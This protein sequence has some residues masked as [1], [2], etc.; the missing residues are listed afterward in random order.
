MADNTNKEK[1]F[2]DVQFS[3]HPRIFEALGTDLV[4]NDT[5]A[6]IELV[7]NSYDAFAE[8]VWVR[9]LDDK[10]DGCIIE[11]EDDGKGMNREIIEDVWG[12]VATPYKTENTTTKSGDKQRRV[13]GEKGLG[14]LSVAR[15]GDHLRMLTQSEGNPCWEVKVKWSEIVKGDN[16]SESI[17][18]CRKY[19]KESPF[20]DS[21]TKLIISKLNSNWEQE[22]INELKDNLSR[23]KFPFSDI[24][25][26]NIFLSGI[27]QD[28]GELEIKTPKFLKNP[29]Y[30]IEGQVD[31]EGNI[32]SEYEYR[33][34]KQNEGRCEE[35][36]IPWGKI[37]EE[38]DDKTEFDYSEKESHCGPFTYEIRAWDLAAEDTSEISQKFNLE[39]SK[40]R[41]AIRAHKG[42]SVYRDDI[43]V[44]PKTD[45]SRDWL[46]LDL[47]R[48]SKIGSRL[49]TS[50]IVGYVS[51]SASD[52]PEIRDT[53]DRERLSSCLEV[54]EFKEIL[55]NIISI[56]E[57]ER[58]KDRKKAE[59]E[60]DDSLKNFLSK[61][62]ADEL[63]EEV[64][65]LAKEGADASDALPLVEEH[66]KSLDK[67][68]ED[69]EKRFVYYSRLSTIGTIAHM[70]VHEVRNQSTSIDSFIEEAGEK[71]SPFESEKLERFYKS[72]SKSI[73][74]LQRLADTFAPLANRN[75][76]RRNRESYLEKNIEGCLMLLPEDLNKLNVEVYIPGSKTTLAVDPGELD[77]ILLNLIS[78]A[79]YWLK[80]VPKDQ[81]AL[82]FEIQKNN[83]TNRVKIGVHD[84]GP[85]IDEDE[86]N[87]I[88]WPGVTN[89]KNG[90]GMGLTIASELVEE[91]DGKM[92]LQQPGELNGA[93]FIF[94]LPLKEQG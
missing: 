19:P 42:V 64:S 62:T 11:V 66:K 10:D 27:E 23:L 7:K 73:Y 32:H 91:Y 25:E 22:N 35:I 33:P 69:I 76:R 83:E 74:S 56:L 79:I 53:S 89:K 37:Y 38:I 3:M 59:K 36:N 26:F 45:D 72:A 43:L 47:R 71:L 28:R 14:R 78:N 34:I 80:D 48:V 57:N 65:E 63:V 58:N 16:A 93:S 20:D 1:G 49:S 86:E 77:A 68:R 40:I 18:Y 90:I 85:G 4:T 17:F 60:E 84:S 88:F 29:K 52:N 15:L 54:G 55:L 67:T 75:F 6:V 30:K 13:V 51:I 70:L 12:T 21:G 81:R 41:Q 50:Q 87:K 46:G 44:L 94:D 92:R 9:F 8:N 5:V 31:D 61:L 39:K 82:E 2:N 24:G